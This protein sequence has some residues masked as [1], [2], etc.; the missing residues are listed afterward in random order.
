MI[1]IN[2]IKFRKNAR[3]YYHEIYYY[4]SNNIYNLILDWIPTIKTSS[5][6]YKFL[7]KY[8]PDLFSF[9]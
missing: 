2:C 9:I 4:N 1:I 3:I 7:L 5:K 8:N 6:I